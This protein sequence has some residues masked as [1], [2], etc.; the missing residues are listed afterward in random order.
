MELDFNMDY[1]LIQTQKKGLELQ[2]LIPLLF[3]QFHNTEELQ[4]I[5]STHT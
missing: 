5:A 4:Q 1:F 3:F 2:M